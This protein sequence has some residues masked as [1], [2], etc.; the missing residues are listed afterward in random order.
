M[1]PITLLRLPMLVKATQIIF[2]RLLALVQIAI[3]IGPPF[4][5]DKR[6]RDVSCS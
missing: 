1:P 3:L 5:Y 6:L 4:N 2:P